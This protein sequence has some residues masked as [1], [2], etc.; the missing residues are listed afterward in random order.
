M[1]KVPFRATVI[2]LVVA[3]AALP[4]D[5]FAQD[6]NG[7]DPGMEDIVVNGTVYHSPYV[8]SDYLPQWVPIQN[9]SPIFPAETTTSTSVRTCTK[10]NA[11]R[12]VGSDASAEQYDA[13]LS[14]QS[15]SNAREY[16]TLIIMNRANPDQYT[17]RTSPLAR[18]ET[19]TE[20]LAQGR[21]PQTSIPIPTLGPFETIIGI[22]HN[23]PPLNDP[24]PFESR[25]PSN[26][27]W[28]T[29]SG[30]KNN[31]GASAVTALAPESAFS[32]YIKGPDGR[33]RQYRQDKP[34]VS[35]PSTGIINGC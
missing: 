33:L 24:N 31:L 13:Q 12:E 14:Q 19:W 16:A 21:A 32:L 20:A 15:D 7:G 28:Q 1:G 35:S 8:Y 30:L 6:G 18:G 27:D 25:M 10:K 11:M 4:I 2:V 23:H 5:G 3:S 34:N 29:Y 17:F 22:A 9:G 26:A